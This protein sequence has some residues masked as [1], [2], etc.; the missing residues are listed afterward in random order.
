MGRVSDGR[1]R[2][3]NAALDLIWEESYGAVTIDDI[4]NRSKV[5][6][7]SFYYFFESKADLAVAALEH[8]W[9][10]H[11]KP[12]MDEIFSPLLSP[13]ERLD[14]AFKR[15]YDRQV[16]LKQETGKV[17]G[18]PYFCIGCEMTDQEPRLGEK[19][20]EIVG[21]KRRYYESAIRDAVAAG[22]IAP[23]D[24]AEKALCLMAMVEGLLSQARILNDT[25][26]LKNLPAMAMGLIGAKSIATPTV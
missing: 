19:M 17:L 10:T 13:L 25:A 3:M 6:K 4:C 16:E 23:C 5:K 22:E 11:T 26:V 14:K 15:A 8:L 20:R 9:S 12:L 21:R 24:P 18:C 7:G 1:E 2:L